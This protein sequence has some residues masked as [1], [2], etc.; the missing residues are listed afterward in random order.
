MRRFLLALL[1]TSGQVL[2]CEM[3]VPI[4]VVFEFDKK[5]TIT[6]EGY[7]NILAPLKHNGWSLVGVQFRKGKNRFSIM[8]YLSESD[9]PGKASFQ[10]EATSKF[11]E[12]SEFTAT[13]TPDPVEKDGKLIMMPCLHEE[14]IEIK[15]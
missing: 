8:Q 5:P 4:E 2:A 7:I 10:I 11:L 1:F 9:Y 6:E 15:I 14:P 12:E 3:E 13:Y